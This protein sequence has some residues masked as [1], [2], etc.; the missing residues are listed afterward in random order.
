VEGEAEIW[1]K[2]MDVRPVEAVIG[3][4]EPLQTK[5]SSA[6]GPS[7]DGRVPEPGVSSQVAPTEG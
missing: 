2:I 6:N 5:A 3:V 1:H 7:G 4:F